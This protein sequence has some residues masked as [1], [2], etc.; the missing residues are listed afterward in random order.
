MDLECNPETNTCNAACCR[1]LVFGMPNMTRQ[2]IEYYRAK[3]CKVEGNRIIV[4]YVCKLLDQETNKCTAHGTS[5]KP[6]ICKTFNRTHLKGFY[7]PKECI[8]NR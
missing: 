6:F 3:G 4:P 5:K 2:L 1:I 7:I 8:Y